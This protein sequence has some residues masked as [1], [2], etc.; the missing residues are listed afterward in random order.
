MT[1]L[2]KARRREQ[3]LKRRQELESQQQA[4]EESKYQYF[5]KIWDK[6][7][8]KWLSESK[9]EKR[10]RPELDRALPTYQTDFQVEEDLL[11]L[12]SG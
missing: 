8:K 2:G 12:V 11:P 6:C 3:A 9:R 1:G 4:D 7:Y 10:S 5:L